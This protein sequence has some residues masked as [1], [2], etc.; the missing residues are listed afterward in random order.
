MKLAEHKKLTLFV[1]PHKFHWMWKETMQRLD[2]FQ[3]RVE[4]CKDIDA[5][6]DFARWLRMSGL[7]WLFTENPQRE[8]LLVDGPAMERAIVKLVQTCGDQWKRGASRTVQA[9]EIEKLN[10]KV[11]VL[12]QTLGRLLP[13]VVTPTVE[14]VSEPS[15]ESSRQVNQLPSASVSVS[16]DGTIRHK[17]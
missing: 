6:S 7:L 16:A 8:P 10:F 9:S 11:D 13:G 2:V 17:G 1:E 15:G 3:K 4:D 14:V 12:A 5:A